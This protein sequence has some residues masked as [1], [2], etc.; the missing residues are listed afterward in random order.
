ME[1]SSKKQRFRKNLTG[2]TNNGNLPE[3]IYRKLYMMYDGMVLIK[4]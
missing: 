3:A 1:M 2:K 4:K